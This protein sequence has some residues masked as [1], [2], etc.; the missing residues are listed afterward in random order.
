MRPGKSPRP[1]Q[2]SN[3]RDIVVFGTGQIAELAH[4]YF[5]HDSQYQVK[6]FV[7]DGAFRKEDTFKGLPVVALEEL[8]GAFAPADY[9]AF[10]AVSYSKLN[11]VRTTKV[12]AL[13]GKGYRLASYISSRATIFPMTQPGHNTFILEDN[14]IQPFVRIGANVTLWSGNHIG[15]HSVI[16]DNVFIASQVVVSGNCRVKQRSFI[17]VNATLRDGITVGE[18]CV[19]GMGAAIMADC[20]DESVYPA[21]RTEPAAVKSSRLRSI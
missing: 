11:S 18:R 17:G 12:E 16:E 13:A 9:G 1:T 15:H 5:G 7:V 6:A 4:F 10:V 14:T 3:M 20:E 19:I 21:A 2:R 8:E